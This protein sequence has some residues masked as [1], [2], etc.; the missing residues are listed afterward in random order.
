M[1][2]SKDVEE[3]LILDLL[4]CC[5][6]VCEPEE[7]RK[8]DKMGDLYMDKE[9]PSTLPTSSFEPSAR[10]LTEQRIRSGCFNVYILAF[11]QFINLIFIYTWLSF[12]AEKGRFVMLAEILLSFTPASGVLGAY[13]R[14]RVWLETHHM[15]SMLLYCSPLFFAMAVWDVDNL[16]TAGYVFFAYQ[17]TLLFYQYKALKIILQLRRDLKLSSLMESAIIKL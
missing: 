17:I 8:Y 5:A 11:V 13:F 2:D 10:E 9:S 15:T 3:T 1:F 6:A 14:S 16:S 7:T 4:P 12:S